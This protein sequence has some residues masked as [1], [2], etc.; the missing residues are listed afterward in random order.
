M[1]YNEDDFWR[2]SEKLQQRT[3]SVQ[4]ESGP[5]SEH[6]TYQRGERNVNYS[7]M[8]FRPEVINPGNV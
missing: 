8:T 4:R 6:G 2:V 3:Q 5:G 7:T 1:R